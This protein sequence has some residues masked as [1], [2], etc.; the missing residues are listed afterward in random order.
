MM[1]RP[2]PCTSNATHQLTRAPS[3]RRS[4]LSPASSSPFRIRAASPELGDDAIREIFV[5]S[6]RVIYRVRDRRVL[7]AAVIHG[8]RMLESTADRITDGD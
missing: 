4:S 6:Y 1:S 7:V 2:S 3:S 5:Y 8:K